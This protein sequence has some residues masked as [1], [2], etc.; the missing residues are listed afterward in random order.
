MMNKSNQTNND[1]HAVHSHSCSFPPSLSSFRT[2]F[3]VNVNARAPTT[4][5]NEPTT[6]IASS[7]FNAS[8]TT[9]DARLTTNGEDHD[10]DNDDD[11]DQGC[12]G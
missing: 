3:L 5:V 9:R 6:V 11:N 7:L 1:A 12:K 10:D 2:L 8:L 4:K